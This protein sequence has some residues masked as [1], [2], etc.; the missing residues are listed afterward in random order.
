MENKV[1]VP[2][3]LPDGR[4]R[5]KSLYK[6]K[7]INR[8]YREIGCS[9]CNKIIL[10]EVQNIKKQ[11]YTFCKECTPKRAMFYYPLSVKVKS[12]GHVLRYAPEHPN[13]KK[14]YIPEHRFVIENSIGRYLEKHEV[15]HHID[16]VKDN[17]SLTNLWITDSSGHTK[18]HNSLNNCVKS[19]MDAGVLIFDKIE[20]IYKPKL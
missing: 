17:N 3:A 19:L 6:G 2:V 1:Q 7:V 13:A 8:Y 5:I 12:S 18:A 15:I 20:G 11:K 14:N 16:C 9:M 4:I 10:R